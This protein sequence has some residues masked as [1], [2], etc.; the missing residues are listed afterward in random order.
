MTKWRKRLR[1]FALTNTKGSSSASMFL[2]AM[3]V[4]ALSV[5]GIQGINAP[6]AQAAAAQCPA[7]STYVTYT[8]SSPNC[9]ATFAYSNTYQT[10]TVPAGVT[11]ATFS[12]KGAQGGSGV[13]A[14]NAGGAGAAVTGTLATTPGQSLY[15]YVGGAGSN[16]SGSTAPIPGGF[17]GGGRG[18]Y[19]GGSAGGGGGGG[20][21][22]IRTTV[23]DY[24]TRLVVAGGGGGGTG[25]SG[26]GNG[27]AAGNPSAPNATSG[28]YTST[29]ATQSGPVAASGYS[30][31]SSLG[32]GSDTNFGVCSLGSSTT[33]CPAGG[34]GGGYYG[35]GAGVTVGAGGSSWYDSTKVSSAA[36]GTSN[37]TGNGVVTITYIAGPTVSTF[38]ATNATATNN[39]YISGTTLTYTINWTMP[40]TGFTASAITLSGTSGGSGTWS[41][42]LTGS[43]A[44]PY[45]LT[46]SNSSALQ[47]TVIVSLDSSQVRDS[48]NNPGVGGTYTNTT[49]IDTIAP[50]I[51]A[52]NFS[53]GSAFQTA[54]QVSVTFSEAV[55]G[56]NANTITL[57]GTA[58]S[59]GTWSKSLTS[60]SGAGPYVFSI[61]N[62]AAINGTITAQVAANAI[63][64]L[65]LNNNVAASSTITQTQTM[66][67]G[68]S[69]GTLPT[70]GAGTITL[71]PNANIYDRTSAANGTLAGLRVSITANYVAGDSMTFTNNNSTTFGTIQTATSAS[72]VLT[73]TYSGSLPTI[74]QW[75]AAL[76]AVKFATS[77]AG[78]A[79]T[80][81][82]ILKPTDGFLYDTMHFY[83]YINNQYSDGNLAITDAAT[84]SY[85]GMTGYLVTVRS[86]A[87]QTFVYSTIQGGNKGTWL[88]AS[89][90]ASAT[91]WKWVV[92]PDNGVQFSTGATA[93]GGA[94]T[95]WLS[96]EPNG[97]AHYI[98]MTTNGGWDDCTACT[99]GVYSAVGYTV[100]FGDQ[101]TGD[102]K[103]TAVLQA[104]GTLAIDAS[105]PVFVFATPSGSSTSNIN[106][107]TITA[108]TGT[109][110]CSTVGTTNGDDFTF[111]NIS[112]ISVA[113][114][115]STVCT[116][117][118]NSAIAG[119]GSGT[120]TLAKAGTYSVLGQNG[121][122]G[123]QAVTTVSISVS[124]P[125][126]TPPVL[127]WT[128]EANSYLNAS[129]NST[130]ATFAFTLSEAV[131]AFTNSAFGFTGTLS[132]TLGTPSGSGTS[133][134]ITVTNCTDGTSGGLYLKANS[135]R[136]LAGNYAAT[137]NG[138]RTITVDTTRP[139]AS[140]TTKPGSY[141]NTTTAH[142]V[143][144]F[145]EAVSGMTSGKLSVTGTSCSIANYVATSSTVYEFDVTGC[146]DAQS[147]T[148]TLAANAGSDAAGNTGPSSAVTASTTI[149]RVAP[150]ASFTTKPSA[151]TNAT[152]SH[153]VV[154]ILAGNFC[155]CRWDRWLICISWN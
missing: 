124:I 126:V 56:V 114:T 7:D 72:G 93:Y 125:D 81:Q 135:M 87:E 47:G 86:A 147:I 142:Y 3:L 85:M 39:G 96:G 106:T 100:E 48:N 76:R 43:G 36:Y 99:S 35:G 46:V 16:G 153:Y 116:I 83:Q 82:V 9:T 146:A 73:L 41:K 6:A 107:F 131:Q 134:S 34:G 132:C 105:T 130:G 119:G 133:W 74:P 68:V 37:N 20:A 121:I 75:Q 57:G 94:Y 44:G 88:G 141:Q 118:A 38:N 154:L 13:G 108:T 45:T 101:V 149:D 139:T 8:Y 122:A 79:R 31:A 19:W 117:T 58:G 22:D 21:S 40:V 51:S 69:L 120:I 151:T 1:K 12:I 109:I 77:T 65:A 18:M 92:G 30:T 152:S 104:T 138:T 150:T 23:G 84:R 148:V 4:F 49:T 24:T 70:F 61:D 15:V 97:S 137:V 27:G 111:T 110:D 91:N 59:N 123:T 64:D 42:S 29:G 11:S 128:N 98:L 78:S 17:N 80:I 52:I 143:V 55:L 14:A 2:V 95:N 60:G 129:T 127:T 115:S 140:F 53:S 25:Y 145:S 28:G 26:G 62:P 54:Q 66:Q 136:D 32:Q 112:S 33:G 90:N 71:L 155:C 50:T 10:W 89:D 63:T 144:T 113:Q 67:P 5:F 103:A 102:S